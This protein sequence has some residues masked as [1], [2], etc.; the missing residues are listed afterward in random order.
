[1]RV[2][3]V[4]FH[5]GSAATNPKAF[6]EGISSAKAAF[7][8]GQSMGFNMHLLDIGG[9]F[10]SSCFSLQGDMSIPAAVNR[11]LDLHFPQAENV[12]IIAEPGR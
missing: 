1:M 8:L 9:G 6:E 12:Q 10:S 5:V 7:S 3:G 4:S 11:A 2:I